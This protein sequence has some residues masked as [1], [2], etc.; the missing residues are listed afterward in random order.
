MVMRGRL[1]VEF[2]FAATEEAVFVHV[3]V[4]AKN[5][6]TLSSGD[7]ERLSL[8]WMPSCGD[9]MPYESRVSRPLL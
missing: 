7:A 5:V 4:S 3:I 1:T 2:V 9:W 8:N 6:W